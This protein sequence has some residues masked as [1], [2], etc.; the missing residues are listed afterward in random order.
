MFLCYSFVLNH[1]YYI[2]IYS[3]S[4]VRKN[5]EKSISI[6]FCHFESFVIIKIYVKTFVFDQFLQTTFYH[7]WNGGKMAAGKPEKRLGE[8]QKRLRISGKNLRRF[9]F[10]SGRFFK[11]PI[12][13]K[14]KGY[15][16]IRLRIRSGSRIRNSRAFRTRCSRWCR[17][18]RAI[19]WQRAPR[20]RSAHRRASA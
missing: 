18:R 6:F 19:R 5:Q 3:D 4:S 14:R 11:S 10:S 7:E 17:I 1:L 16:S 15:R 2:Y 12:I 9:L 20:C 13:F 8:K